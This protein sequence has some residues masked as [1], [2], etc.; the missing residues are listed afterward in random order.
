MAGSDRNLYPP[1]ARNSVYEVIGAGTHNCT[2]VFTGAEEM[3]D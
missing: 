1:N 2:S 3:K